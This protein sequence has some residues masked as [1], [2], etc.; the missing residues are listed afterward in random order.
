MTPKEIMLY[1][2]QKGYTNIYIDGGKV[3]QSFI[4]ENLLDELIISS[5]PV[6][7]GEGISLFGWLDHDIAFKHMHTRIFSKWT[8]NEPLRKELTIMN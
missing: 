2:S 6:L 7:I 3:I 1:L 4:K 5:V 8:Y